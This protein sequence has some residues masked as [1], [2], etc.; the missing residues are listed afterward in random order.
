LDFHFGT[1]SILSDYNKSKGIFKFF[2]IGLCSS[3]KNG[4]L[5]T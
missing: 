1:S 2:T 4:I 5:K 3:L